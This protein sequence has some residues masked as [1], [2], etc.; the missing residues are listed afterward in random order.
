MFYC[1]FEKYLTHENWNSL[2]EKR[3][4]S[5]CITM[6]ALVSWLEPQPG[7][8]DASRSVTHVPRSAQKFGI[9]ILHTLVV[10]LQNLKR[11]DEPRE[12]EA[13]GMQT[14]ALVNEF[15]FF[16]FWPKK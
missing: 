15:D 13:G 8:L 3:E 2:V 1:L 9:S 5:H 4:T 14:I 7:C 10:L 16:F 11:G 6:S 12:Q